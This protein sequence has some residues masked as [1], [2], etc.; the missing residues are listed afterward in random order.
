MYYL[1]RSESTVL[2][3][4]IEIIKIIFLII[5][6]KINVYLKKYLKIYDIVLNL[7]HANFALMFLACLFWRKSWAVAITRSSLLCKIFNV[8]HY[9]KSI[10]AIK[11]KLVHY[12]KMQLQ[13]KGRNSENYSFGV[14][15]LF[16]FILKVEWW[17]LTRWT[18]AP[19]AVL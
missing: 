12:G 6:Q 18:L 9:S 8:A 15:P 7:D 17:P 11:T 4:K 19:H 2:R 13:D 1:I 10:K 5:L 3:L 14:M 16:N